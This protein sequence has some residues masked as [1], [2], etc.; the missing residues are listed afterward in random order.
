M[1]WFQELYEHFEYERHAALSE[2]HK[3]YVLK[4]LIHNI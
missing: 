3:Q 1:N 2:A 4:I